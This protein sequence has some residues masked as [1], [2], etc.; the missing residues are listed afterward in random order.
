MPSSK[1][2]KKKEPVAISRKKQRQEARL[3]KKERKRGNTN[4]AVDAGSLSKK[5]KE[6]VSFHVES[7]QTPSLKKKFS[8]L[9]ALAVRK[10]LPS[11][12]D[13][14]SHG[15]SKNPGP[16]RM[17][18]QADPLLARDDAEI[19]YLERKLGL[20][21]GRS[22]AGGKSKLAREYEDDGLGE[23]FVSFL[24]SLDTV[25][26]SNVDNPSLNGRRDTG[27][28]VWGENREEGGEDEEEAEEEWDQAAFEKERDDAFA[29]LPT[30][31][32]EEED[33]ED[34]DSVDD[35][36]FAERS[37]V[38]EKKIVRLDSDQE[39]ANSLRTQQ[40][41]EVVD[42][43]VSGNGARVE[44]ESS[45]DDV[46][47]SADPLIAREDAEIA[48]LERKLGMGGSSS[49]KKQKEKGTGG[50]SR[51]YDEMDANEFGDGFGTFLQELDEMS[52]RIRKHKRP[53][54]SAA[55]I[56]KQKQQQ[57]IREPSEGSSVVAIY[58]DANC[59]D[60]FPSNEEDDWSSS[61]DGES[62]GGDDDDDDVK[63]RGKDVMTADVEVAGTDVYRP[64]LGQDIYGRSTAPVDGAVVAQKY[65]PPAARRE[66]QEQQQQQ[67]GATAVVATETAERAEHLSRLRRKV[68]SE[69]P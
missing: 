28:G 65:L 12:E 60:S 10:G 61:Q 51:V 35:D 26:R 15:K 39:D 34:Q 42:D 64:T 31:D 68:T 4:V 1:S 17:P 24:E 44:T 6:C 67:H 3:K 32:E 62:D 59:D 25:V 18:T 27:E 37:G 63:R 46:I 56:S 69:L 58:G 8:P 36:F 19:A 14:G 41:G 21:G 49:S 11:E 23:D 54:S 20:R 40:T 57:N 48:Y 50:R 9:E 38:L 66:R 30:D 47:A 22:S 29:H 2:S 33:E 5:R 13:D 16:P 43:E 52:A 53:P 55:A 7:S 45:D